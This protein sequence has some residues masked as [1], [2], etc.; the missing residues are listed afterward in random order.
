MKSVRIRSY[1]GSHFTERYGRVSLRIQSKCGKIR[2]RMTP[3]TDTFYAV[4]VYASMLKTI[5][6]PGRVTLSLNS[7]AVY[8]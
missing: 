8:L 2:T 7:R 6:G 5:I 4:K 1:S 3:N